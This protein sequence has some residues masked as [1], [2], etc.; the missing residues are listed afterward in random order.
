MSYWGEG[1]GRDPELVPWK[2]K[3]VLGLG[4]HS[5]KPFQTSVWAPEAV[6]KH[7]L[8]RSRIRMVFDISASTA[9]ADR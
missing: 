9:S 7:G 2:G 1:P 5:S 3:L 4:H 8:T 6:G